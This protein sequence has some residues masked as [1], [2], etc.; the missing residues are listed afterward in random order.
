MRGEASARPLRALESRVILRERRTHL[1][2]SRSTP[3]A[4]QGPPEV[5]VTRARGCD[6]GCRMWVFL[7]PV[8]LLAGATFAGSAAQM[9]SKSSTVSATG[10]A[11]SGHTLPV[12][13]PIPFDP[14]Y[15]Q[16]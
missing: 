13:G 12:N 4:P 10:P 6:S 5:E 3:F 2:S 7:I 8:I 15:R 9:S 11:S 1:S 16:R 14:S